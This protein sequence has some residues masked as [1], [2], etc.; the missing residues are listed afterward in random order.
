MINRLLEIGRIESANLELKIEPL[1]FAALL[2]KR[3][4]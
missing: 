2:G 4:I 1:D 3:V